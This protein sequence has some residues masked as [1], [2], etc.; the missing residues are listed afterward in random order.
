MNAHVRI[1]P[2]AD[3]DFD[4]TALMERERIKRVEW[5]Y[6]HWSVVLLDGRQASAPTVGEA[7]AKAKLPGATNVRKLY[8]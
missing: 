1:T 4:L 2:N 6:P 8:A 3:G 7:L 5:F